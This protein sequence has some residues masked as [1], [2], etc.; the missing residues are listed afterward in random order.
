MSYLLVAGIIG[1]GKFVGVNAMIL[2]MFYKVQLEDVRFIM[3][4][5]KMLEFSVYEGI[6]YLLTEVVI[7]MKD[8]VNALRWCVNEMERR[9]KLMFALGV[10]NLAG[11]NEKI[12]EVDRMMRS[13][14]DSYWK[15]GDS[16]DVQYSVLKKEL[17]IVV[18]V[19]EFVDLMMTVGKKVEE[20]IVRLA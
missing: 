10:R 1:F 14:L 12:V 18:L 13:I 17:Y 3:I 20:L 15:S 16:M 11:Y 4:D 8:V 6:S 5:S 9:Y 2:S 19:D 7:D